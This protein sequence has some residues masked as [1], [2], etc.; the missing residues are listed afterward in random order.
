M[1]YRGDPQIYQRRSTR[2]HCCEPCSNLLRSQAYR[3]RHE[4]D[5]GL[6]PPKARPAFAKFFCRSSF[7]N[8]QESRSHR[9]T[10][11]GLIFEKKSL[12]CSNFVK[13]SKKSMLD[14]AWKHLIKTFKHHY[15]PLFKSCFKSSKNETSLG[16]GTEVYPICSTPSARHLHQGEIVLQSPV[17]C[18][19]LCGGVP[20]HRSMEGLIQGKWIPN[21][22]W[23]YYICSLLS[24]LM[25]E[26]WEDPILW[27]MGYFWWIQ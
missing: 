19:E 27:V 20:G 21:T 12:W 18:I 4:L 16:S 23:P 24:S 26:V 15:N 25:F 1:I 17:R 7:G 8:T 2:N 13:D 5:H 10:G 3:Y 11:F 22:G 9:L 14:M 6:L